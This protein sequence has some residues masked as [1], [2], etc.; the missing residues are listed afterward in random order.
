MEKES[1]STTLKIAVSLAAAALLQTIAP[2]FVPY[3]V[4]RWL[5]YIDWLLLVVVYVGLQ[6]NPVQSLVTG[7][8]AGLLH[9]ALTGGRV[10]GVSGFAYVVAAYAVARITGLIVADNL[11]VRFLAVAAASAA[12]TGVRLLLYWMLKFDLPVLA[13]GRNIAATIV[14]SLF[15]NLIVSVLFYLLLDRFFSKDAGLKR[16]RFEARRIRPRL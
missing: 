16:R 8:L 15:A 9:D 4:W 12:N 2:Q 6:R 14:F 13:G 11:L 3:A 10:I 1:R 7:T 5:G